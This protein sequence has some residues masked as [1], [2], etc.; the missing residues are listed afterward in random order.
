[1]W[2][3]K[4]KEKRLQGLDDA[5]LTGDAERCAHAKDGLAPDDVKRLIEEDRR[6][7]RSRRIRDG[8]CAKIK[9]VQNPRV[10]LLFS[11]KGVGA[12]RCSAK[13]SAPI[14]KSTSS[15]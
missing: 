14:K 12:L 8:P 4:A 5:P 13:F 15:G 6:G 9:K 7:R 2:P 10:A 11:L 1:M 3:S